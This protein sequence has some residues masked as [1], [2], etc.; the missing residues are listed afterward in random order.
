MPVPFQLPR[1][2]P[3]LDTATLEARNFPVPIV[4]DAL[5]DA[6]VKILQYR[7]KENWSQRNFDEARQLAE[8]CQEL[9]VLFVLNDRADFA[10]LLRSA[11]HIGQDDLP[12]V[13]ARNVISDEV[14]GLSTH[15]RSQLERGNA[16][17][18]EYLSIGPIFSTRSKLRPDPVVG[19][20]GLGKLREA[21]GK[22]LVAIGG[23]TLEN[24]RETLDSKA[25]SLAII[26]G[27]LP[28]NVDKNAIRRHAEEWLTLLA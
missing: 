12:P 14:M 7:H 9:G 6:G 1:F 20:N 24:A 23:I 28:E 27:L 3:I 18:V 15:N 13:A 22:P 5:F 17:P 16:E 25:D 21:T 10:R 2:Y 4:A 8:R 26:S 11:L 19:L